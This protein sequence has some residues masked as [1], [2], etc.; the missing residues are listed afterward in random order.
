M[1]LDLNDATT[2]A[3]KLGPKKY[4]SLLRRFFND[5]DDAITRNSGQVFQYVGDEVVVIWN[6]RQGLKNSNCIRAFVMALENLEKNKD[7]Y[8]E[9]Y[10]IYPRFKA[11]LHI[12]E[13]SITEI[14]ISK[15]EIA[16]H[17]DA[18][19]TTAR[20]CGSAHKLGRN[21]LISKTLY[22]KLPKTEAFIYKELGEHSFK[23][24]HEKIGL[25][26]LG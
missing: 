20:I 26:C 12:G 14:G 18:I 3:E 8:L 7:F 19:N 11:A 23:G 25:Y 17:G 22:E 6:P 21:L 16:Y 10:D 5:L 2:I 15:K 9:T 1:F 4:S 13:V 24:K